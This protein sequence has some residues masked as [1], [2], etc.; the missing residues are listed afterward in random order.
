MSASITVIVN[1]NTHWKPLL[2]DIL[3]ETTFDTVELTWYDSLEA[4]RA[5][6]VNESLAILVEETAILNQ[7]IG[8][9]NDNTEYRPLV[10]ALGQHLGENHES[11]IDFFL[12]IESE[13]SVK[14]F[15][16][17]LERSAKYLGVVNSLTREIS[18]LTETINQQT[19]LRREVEILK[20]AIVRNVSHELKTPLLQ[21]KSAVS[22]MSEDS[23]DA[24]L[25]SYAKNATGRLEALVKN[26]TLLG[27]SLDTNRGPVI[28]RDT[29]EYAK[30]NLRRTWE[31]RE[32]IQRIV[33]NI[34]EDLPPVLADKQGISTVLQLLVDNALKFSKDDVVVS[35]AMRE[36][37]VEF[38]VADRGIG[39]PTYSLQSIFDS[40]V[41]LDSS[42]TRRYGGA[43]V[44]LAIVKLILDH[45]DT[46]IKVRSEVDQGSTFSF[47]LLQFDLS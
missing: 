28:V 35:A 7:V 38:S 44:G 17:T 25:V 45:H 29:I 10:V 23:S 13:K 34:E 41:Q 14:S 8:L 31:H 2:N 24:E 47:Q 30:R 16:T 21:V 22:L 27:S 18:V 19:Q 46:E 40:F 15:L 3:I 5:T 20:N 33:V 42:T 12:D 39:I 43:G 32:E 6:I 1:E 9:I 4:D 11:D 26:I 37:F 36:S